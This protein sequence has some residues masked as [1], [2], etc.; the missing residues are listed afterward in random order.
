MIQWINITSCLGFGYDYD[1]DFFIIRLEEDQEVDTVLH[2]SVGF[3]NV[4]DDNLSGLYRSSYKSG[5]ETR[6]LA[7]TQFWPTAARQAFPCLDEPA[8]KAVFRIN[9]GRPK[10]YTTASNMPLMREGV[11]L[12]RIDPNEYVMDMFEP[13]LRMSSYLVAFLISDFKPRVSYTKD[14]KTEFRVWAKQDAYNQT[15]RY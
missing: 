10:D 5:N 3:T 7:V 2:V 14:N 15:E 11:P 13:T 12:R 4:L 9:L 6:Y 1:R 8:L